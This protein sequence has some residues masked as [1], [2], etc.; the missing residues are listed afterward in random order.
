[1]Q[2]FHPNTWG[3]WATYM[4]VLYLTHFTTRVSLEVGND[5]KLVDVQDVKQTPTY[6]DEI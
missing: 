6:R 5:R 4:F 3:M 1:M 2:A